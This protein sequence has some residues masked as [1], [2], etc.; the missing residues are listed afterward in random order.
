MAGT[1]RVVGLVASAAATGVLLATPAPAPASPAPSRSPVPAVVGA[2]GADRRATPTLTAR[3]ERDGGRSLSAGEPLEYGDWYA[4]RFALE[5]DDGGP[6]PSGWLTLTDRGGKV[7][8]Q[9]IGRPFDPGTTATGGWRRNGL[10]TWPGRVTLR[11]RY[12]GDDSYD[13][14]ERS[15]TFRYRKAGRQPGL[16][17]VL[18]EMSRVRADRRSVLAVEVPD[19]GARVVVG[20]EGRIVGRAR[21][22]R[23]GG[24]GPS[25][26]TFTCL[27]FGRANVVIPDGLPSGRQRVW[28]GFRGNGRF[29]PSSRFAWLDV[30]RR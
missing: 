13:P 9:R 11:V 5:P 2:A 8:F 24:A 22:R 15:V 29:N 25:M 14:V 18:P 1:R 16:P 17:D 19:G 12:Y 3:V 26:E 10:I 28:L 4:V 6:R 30:P 23:V 20:H 27:C 7:W 21:S